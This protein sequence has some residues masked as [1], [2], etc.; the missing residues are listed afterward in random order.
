LGREYASGAKKRKRKSREKLQHR[1]ES[2]LARL[3]GVP[4]ISLKI[5]GEELAIRG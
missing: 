1:A 2:P 3:Q 4:K 5:G